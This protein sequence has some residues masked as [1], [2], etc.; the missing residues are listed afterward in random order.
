MLFL[1]SAGQTRFGGGDSSEPESSCDKLPS[2]RKLVLSEPELDELE[3][4]TSEPEL[5]L[6]ELELLL[7]AMPMA[8]SRNT[9]LQKTHFEVVCSEV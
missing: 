3:L 2:E 1:C 8:P 9:E 5:L 4:L 7:F 6:D